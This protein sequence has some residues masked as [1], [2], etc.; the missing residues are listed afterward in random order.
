MQESISLTPIATWKKKYVHLFVVLWYEAEL[1]LENDRL[2]TY[3]Q[4][5]WSSASKSGNPGCARY[6]CGRPAR[7]YL[8]YSRARSQG[9]YRK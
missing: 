1:R 9:I 2:V 6:N 5:T 8:P 7:H 4:R 3:R